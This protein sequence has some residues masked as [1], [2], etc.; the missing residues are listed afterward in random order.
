MPPAI[1]ESVT[2]ASREDAALAVPGAK[3]ALEA[4][5]EARLGRVHARQRLGIE[6]DHAHQVFRRARSVFHP[7]NWYSFASLVRNSMRLTGV[8]G[9]AMR[10]ARSLDTVHHPAAVPG[11]PRAFHGFRILHLSD[12]HI[13]VSEPSAH[14]LI[15]AVRTVDYDLCVLTG[16]YRFRTTGDIAPTLANMARLRASLAGDVYAVLGNHDSVKMLP[17]LEAMGIRI[18]MN[19]SVALERGGERLYLAGIDDAHF[20]GVENFDKA[21]AGVP[22]EATTVLLSH[23]PEVYLQAAHAG[24]D[25]L[26]CGHTH[27]GQICLPGR[28]PVMLDARIPRRFGRGSWRYQNMLGYTSPGSGTSIVEVRLNCPPEI[29][30]HTLEAGRP[31]AAVGVIS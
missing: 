27:G 16:D 10:N 22:P 21:L 26:L 15:E 11:L 2:A 17:D 25:L 14:A 13:D 5:L 1:T 12:L 24:V 9:R 20:F 7:E 3:G 19:E 18:L 6:E 28:I 4:R 30:L 31:P 8:Y 29:T 23:T